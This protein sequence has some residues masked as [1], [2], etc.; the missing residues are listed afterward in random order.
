VLHLARTSKFK[1]K[2]PAFAILPDQVHRRLDIGTYSRKMTFLKQ[3]F[4]SGIN[5]TIGVLLREG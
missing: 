5:F 4:L 2:T 3:L 1:V